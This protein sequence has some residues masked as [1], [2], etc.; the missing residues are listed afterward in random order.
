MRTLVV[1]GA[2]FIGSHL[3]DKLLADNFEVIIYDNFSAGRRENLENVADKVEIIE[4]DIRDF[5]KFKEASKGSDYVLH[6]AAATSVPRSLKEPELFFD[7]NLKGTYNVLEASRLN[8]VK[9]VVFASSSS[10][11]GDNQELPLKEEKTGN[12][13]SPYAVSK[14]AGE[15]LCRFFWKTHGL[16]TVC[17]RY[18]NVFGPRQNPDS[19]Y[20]AVIPKFIKLM[21][22]GQQP[23]I[24]GDGEQK[25][26]FTYISN[27]VHANM[28]A[29]TAIDAPGQVI[30][31]ANQKGTTVNELVSMLKSIMGTE[32]EAEHV[33]Q[34]PGDIRHSSG[35]NTKAREILGYKILTDVYDGLE[36]TVN[37]Q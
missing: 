14:Y 27:V 28:L 1:G 34:R 5:D 29:L 8:K 36:L 11:Y 25:R 18:F 7:V 22:E 31:A 30:N 2:G 16:E 19:Q 23:Q 26:D 32:I 37:S 9:R 12:R 24:Y 6:Q 10:V 3:V 17:L 13:L 33:D 21:K 20:A 4:G 35:D 15:D